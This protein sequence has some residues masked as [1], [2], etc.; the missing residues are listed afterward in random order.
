MLGAFIETFPFNHLRELHLTSY[1]LELVAEEWKELFEPLRSVEELTV[2]ESTAFNGLPEAL[3][4]EID[5]IPG[6][7]S[8]TAVDATTDNNDTNSAER[9]PLLFPKLRYLELWTI[10]FEAFVSPEEAPYAAYY[11]LMK[12]L[13][14]RKVTLPIDTLSISHCHISQIVV[15]QF[16]LIVPNVFCDGIEKGVPRRRTAEATTTE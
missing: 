13:T 4:M 11:R 15:S 9:R 10:D 14:G 8:T 7:D 5:P 12:A 16:A 1:D 3:R 2:S 6:G